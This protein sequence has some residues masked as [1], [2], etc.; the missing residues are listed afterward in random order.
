[1]RIDLHPK[2]TRTIGVGVAVA[3][4]AGV[5]MG[6]ALKPT[7]ALADIGGPQ[8][9][10]A[11]GGERFETAAYDEGTA[12][13]EGVLPDY[14]VGADWV[15]ARQPQVS[16]ARYAEPKPTAQAPEP[17]PEYEVVVYDSPDDLPARVIPAAWRDEVEAP[18]RYPSEVGNMPTESDLPVPP[19]APAENDLG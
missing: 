9:L 5:L 14:V 12:A 18:P 4:V 11:G 13:Y 8:Q 6:A 3:A 10:L 15:K 19:P 7:L 17:E 16:P 1:M 2:D